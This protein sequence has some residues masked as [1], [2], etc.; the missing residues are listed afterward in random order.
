MSQ[1]KK[2]VYLPGR[3]P[4]QKARKGLVYN[5]VTVDFTSLG[6]CGIPGGARPGPD[7]MQSAIRRPIGRTRNV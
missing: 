7:G 1:Q 5:N 6:T 3:P 4:T 2:G